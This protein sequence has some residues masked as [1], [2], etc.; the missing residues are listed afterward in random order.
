MSSFQS[1]RRNGTLT[2]PPFL[3]CPRCVKLPSTLLFSGPFTR[4][5]FFGILYLVASHLVCRRLLPRRRAP[6]LLLALLGNGPRLLLLLASLAR[7]GR[8]TKISAVSSSPGGSGH[9]GD[10]RKAHGRSQPVGTTLPFRM[11]S[12]LPPL[13]RQGLFM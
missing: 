3:S 8:I 12:R 10:R 5:G 9:S 11:L 2:L 1:G 7:R 6:L 4:P 13:W